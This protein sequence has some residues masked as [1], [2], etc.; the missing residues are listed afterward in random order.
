MRYV[1]WKL[2]DCPMFVCCKPQYGKERSPPYDRDQ[3]RFLR[4]MS[5]FDEKALFII[6]IAEKSYGGIVE[7]DTDAINEHI[8]LARDPIVYHETTT[9]RYCTCGGNQPPAL[10]RRMG[11]SNL[12][13]S[14]C[15]R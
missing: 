7:D 8:L 3:K 14:T 10:T 6:A 1:Q 13:S 9:I 4:V 2:E 11:K 12:V 15:I 5:S